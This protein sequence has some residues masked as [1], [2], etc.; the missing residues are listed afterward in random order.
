[1]HFVYDRQKEKVEKRFR[2]WLDTLEKI[3]GLPTTER[4]G[5]STHYKKQL[6]ESNPYCA[7][8]GQEIKILNDV[9]VDHIEMYIFGGKT[10]PSNAR[11]VHRYCNR[12]RRDK[13]SQTGVLRSSSFGRYA[14]R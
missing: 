6:W 13:N 7:I 3:V 1:M 8:C 9:E 2:I 10:L 14:R 5:F 11:L 4:R 12:A